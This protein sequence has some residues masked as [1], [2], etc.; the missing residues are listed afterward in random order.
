MMTCGTAFAEKWTLSSSVGATETYNWYSGENQPA[1]N[2]FV[3]SLTGAI[4]FTGEGA[5]LKLTGSVGATELL[6]A[7]QS[8]NNSFA[9]NVSVLAKAEAIEKFFFIDASAN[10]SQTFISPFGPQPANLT[11]PTNNRYTSYTYNVSPYIQGAFSPDVTYLVRDDNTWT[12]S[13][14]YGN[15]SL[16]VPTTYNNYLNAEVDA[17]GGLNG[18]SVQYQ[19]LYY[20]NGLEGGTDTL[21]IARAIV[22]HHFDPQLTGSLRGGY[23]SARFPLTSDHSA[24]YGAGLEWRP[25]DRTDLS[26]YWEH[27]FFGSSYNWQLTHRLPNV[28]LAATFTRGLSSFPQLALAIPAGVPVAPFIDSAFATR[29]PDPAER[30]AA[31]AQFLAQNG[32]PP[33]L[34]SPL[35]FYAAQI[36][37]QQ[38]ESVSAVWIGARNALG[39]TVFNNRSEAISGTGSPL[40]PAF[41]FGA[42]NTQTGVGVNYSHRL[43]ASYSRTTPNTTDP[44]VPTFKSNNF[45]ASVYVSTNLSP[46]TTAS[47]G[48]TYS[49]FNTPGAGSVGSSATAG[50]YASINHTF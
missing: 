11:T 26:G 37:L 36:T 33:T 27:Q 18:L 10:I 41:Q 32:L 21:Q 1:N 7:G 5:R 42:N 4:A 35:N 40:P 28:A 8:E 50:V 20:D 30:A 25:T 17:T 47:A 46:K 24:I 22:S 2:G 9:P 44:G 14:T 3:T 13:T 6:Y 29:I 43:S 16:K 12:S 23:E 45:N 39:F 31:V 38:T 19:R 48:V 49:D 15:S 34:I